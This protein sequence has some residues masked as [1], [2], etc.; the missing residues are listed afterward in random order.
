VGLENS[1]A[2]RPWLATLIWV[3]LVIG[4]YYLTLVGAK[5]A[6]EQQILEVDGSYELNPHFRDDID[7]RRRFSSRLLVSILF[8]GAALTVLGYAWPATGFLV[9]AGFLI[10]VELGIYVRHFDN[11]GTY[12]M[13]VR[14]RDSAVG[15]V[16]WSRP[17]VYRRSSMNSWTMGAFLLV[18]AAL[19]GSPMLLGG[20]LGFG[21]VGWDHA[22]LARRTTTTLLA[23]AADPRES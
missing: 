22:H 13:L 7:R 1:I 5:L 8:W 10:V 17:F 12:R 6:R 20:A 14:H 11:I 4:D 3:V 2:E 18:L 9:A 23:S 15:Y 19:T 21:R 16:R